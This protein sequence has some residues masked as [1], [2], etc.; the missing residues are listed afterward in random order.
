MHNLHLSET[1]KVATICLPLYHFQLLPESYTVKPVFKT[2]W[3]IGTTWELRTVTS[4]TP[5]PGSNQYIETDLRNKTTSEFRTVFHSPLG[6][7]N[8]SQLPLYTLHNKKAVCLHFVS[9]VYVDTSLIQLTCRLCAMSE[10]VRN[11]D[12]EA[13]YTQ[14]HIQFYKRVC[15]QCPVYIYRPYPIQVRWKHD[16]QIQWDSATMHHDIGVAFW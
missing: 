4:Y 5:V 12:K 8:N 11:K 7:P 9:S 14:V 6:V 3:E 15:A 13:T 10:W 1:A 2:T 16:G